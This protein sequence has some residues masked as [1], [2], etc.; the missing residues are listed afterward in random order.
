MKKILSAYAAGFLILILGT[1]VAGGGIGVLFLLTDKVA[2]INFTEQVPWFRPVVIWSA[3][4]IICVCA[5]LCVADI[6]E[7]R[8]RYIWYWPVVAASFSSF[9]NAFFGEPMIAPDVICV[10]LVSLVTII[11]IRAKTT[12][13]SVQA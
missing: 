12:Q 3:I 10:G 6:L 11:V 5:T 2:G 13:S 8:D 1:V 7:D 9:G 4:S